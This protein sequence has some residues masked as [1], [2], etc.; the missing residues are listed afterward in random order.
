MDKIRTQSVL[1]EKKCIKDYYKRATHIED[2]GIK[3]K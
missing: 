2:A 1:D 3:S